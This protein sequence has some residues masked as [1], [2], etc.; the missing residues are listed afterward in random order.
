M[1]L[2]LFQSNIN[3]NLNCRDISITADMDSGGWPIND[4]NHCYNRLSG[5]TITLL[6]QHVI[7]AEAVRL[8]VREG[9]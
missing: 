3:A 9:L 8:H 1:I 4:L 6:H 2:K 7:G 5:S